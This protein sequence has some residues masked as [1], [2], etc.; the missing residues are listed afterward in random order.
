VLPDPPLHAYVRLSATA[1][2]LW[3]EVGMAHQ[4]PARIP[5]VAPG[6]RVDGL[7]HYDVVECFLACGDGRYFELELGAGG[8]YL[9]LAFA[10]PRQRV[11]DFARERLDVD[12]LSTARAWTARCAVPRAWLPEPVARVNAFAIA[13]GEFAVHAPVGG[14]E[15]DFH[16]PEAYPEARVAGWTT[17][18]R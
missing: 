14:S 2:A 9:A 18:L 13:R 6:A 5:D 7:W 15:P 17:P 10:A 4:L 16:R 12:W 8:H 1:D 11:R 3:V